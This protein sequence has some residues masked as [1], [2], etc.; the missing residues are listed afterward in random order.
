MFVP[1]ELST[2]L[3]SV[4]HNSCSSSTA[5]ASSVPIY[6]VI[7]PLCLVCLICALTMTVLVVSLPHRR[8]TWRWRFLLC[9]CLTADEL[10]D[11]GSCCVVAWQLMNST[12]TVL[13]V[14]LPDRCMMVLIVSCCYLSG[15][16]LNDAVQ[17]RTL[18]PQSRS[19]STSWQ[20][21]QVWTDPSVT[22]A[23]HCAYM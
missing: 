15:D 21:W 2:L 14:S 16:K 3:Y 18:H 1:M 13:V 6:S 7:S 12:L 4:T 9:R 22:Q 20:I 5:V 8:W 17:H 10:D 19:D 23:V 11:D